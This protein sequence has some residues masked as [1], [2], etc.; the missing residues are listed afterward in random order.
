MG[1]VLDM[2]GVGAPGVVAP[3]PAEPSGVWR[4]TWAVID[5]RLG[6]SALAYPVPRHA[7]GI[8]YILGGVTA[9]GMLVL[10]VTG[11]WLAQFYN[12]SPDHAHDSVQYI[13]STAPLGNLMRGVHFWTSNI[14]MV[15]VLLHMVRTF[16]TGSYK[17]P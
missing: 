9:V 14:V 1:E 5:E 11:V 15:T 17:R 10:I 12:P 3:A 7:N 8:A 4:R 13:I 6:L 2:G 16:A